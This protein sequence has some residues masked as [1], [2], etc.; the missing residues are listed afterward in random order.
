M[1]ARLLQRRKLRDE[2][3]HLEQR[4]HAE[5]GDRS[6]DPQLRAGDDERG[7]LERAV[8]DP[9][10]GLPLADPQRVG[11]P[12]LAERLHAAENVGG[13]GFWNK[14]ANYANEKMLPT[15]DGAVLAAAA[16]AGLPNVKTM[17]IAAAFNGRRL[18]EKA[19]GLLEEEGL[20]SWKAAEAPNKSEWFNQIRTITAIFPPYEI[21]EDL[22]P[23]YWAQLALRNCLAQAYNGG[24]PRAEPARSRHRAELG[25]ASRTCHCTSH[26]PAYARPPEYAGAGR[27]ASSSSA[28]TWVSTARAV[29]SANA[30]RWACGERHG[31]GEEEQGEGGEAADHPPQQPHEIAGAALGVGEDRQHGRD[32]RKRRQQAAQ[33]RAQPAGDRRQAEHERQGAR[34]AQR[35]IPARRRR[36]HVRGLASAGQHQQSRHKRG[37][38]ERQRLLGGDVKAAEERRESH[39]HEPP[40]DHADPPGQP[41]ASRAY[42]TTKAIRDTSRAACRRRRSPRSRARGRSRRRAGSGP[43]DR[44]ARDQPAHACAEAARRQGRA[45]D[46]ARCEQHLDGDQRHAGMIAYQG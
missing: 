2:K 14:D 35:Q 4:R 19:V 33:L 15:I 5:V 7:L 8:L 32:D 38:G 6:G 28:T 39:E 34:G 3:L 17:D 12:L 27:R 13:C 43:D 24:T 26:D 20:S 25:R 36:P 41:S 11:L 37:Q 29:A 22:H 42:T 30:A 18:C 21:Q 44:Q 45:H 9:R 46:E 23:N 16:A 1:V 40:D 10:A 31:E